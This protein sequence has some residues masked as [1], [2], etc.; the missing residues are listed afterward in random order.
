MTQACCHGG[1]NSAW[2]LIPPLENGNAVVIACPHRASI[3]DI[4]QVKSKRHGENNRGVAE[5]GQMR[6]CDSNV[7][8]HSEINK[9]NAASW[10]NDIV[11]THCFGAYPCI[12]RYIALTE[13]GSTGD[14]LHKY[15]HSARIAESVVA[16]T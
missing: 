1:S 4:F 14:L 9:I 16:G 5:L 7:N 12:S 6:R 8:R 11:E 3:K 15:A 2:R 10:G 13:N